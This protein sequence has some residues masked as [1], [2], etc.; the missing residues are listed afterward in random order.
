MDG[1]AILDE[2]R[3]TFTREMRSLPGRWP[4]KTGSGSGRLYWFARLFTRARSLMFYQAAFSGNGFPG[5]TVCS[6][7]Y[8]QTKLVSNGIRVQRVLGELGRCGSQFDTA[9]INPFPSVNMADGVRPF[10][11]SC[12]PYA[13]GYVFAGTGVGSPAPLFR[14]MGGCRLKGKDHAACLLCVH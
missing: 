9:D 1:S 11:F 5:H 7:W 6:A 3:S 4:M 14:R 13:A 10:H 8:N 2:N 12:C